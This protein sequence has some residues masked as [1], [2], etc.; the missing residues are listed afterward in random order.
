MAVVFDLD[1]TLIDSL[2]TIAKAG[3]AVLADVN[4]QELD[5]DVYRGFVGLGEQV[6]IDRLIAA[7]TLSVTDR[8]VVMEH[9]IKRYKEA[10]SQT[11]LFHGVE[12]AMSD[13][14][15]MQV[16]I[17][18]CTNKP[19]AALS[20]VLD[21]LNWQDMFGSVIAGDTLAV[22]KPHPEPLQKAFQDL[23]STTGIYVG[24]SET[25][26]ETA[27]RAGVPFVLF[28]KGIRV[29]PIEDIPHDVAFDDFADLAEIVKDLIS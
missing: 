22:R 1:G 2:P 10:S 4:L 15:A 9:F 13:L 5:I 23:G 21:T 18:L 24:D 3:N 28:T 20:V 16:P 25:D 26:A 27:K 29:S 14:K 19:Q 12:K 11:D 6:F 17:G 7:T 8:P